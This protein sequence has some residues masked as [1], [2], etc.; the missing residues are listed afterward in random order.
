MKNKTSIK[1]TYV[2]VKEYKG[3]PKLR[4]KRLCTR[5]TPNKYDLLSDYWLPTDETICYPEDLTKGSYIWNSNMEVPMYVNSTKEIDYLK[6]NDSSLP[7]YRFSSF[8]EIS[9]HLISKKTILSI[10]D[11]HDIE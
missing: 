10:S 9:N 4:S 5:P 7:Y 2:L 11:I 8:T 6:S 3:S 1:R